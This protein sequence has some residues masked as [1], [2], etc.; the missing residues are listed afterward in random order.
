MAHP[1]L[2]FSR[3]LAFAALLGP[4]MPVIPVSDEMI[5]IA[6]RNIRER[7]RAELE[8]IIAQIREYPI[9]ED[10]IERMAAEIRSLYE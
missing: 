6:S 9:S 10:E 5:S 2:S 4:K 8:P 1:D 3:D 7:L